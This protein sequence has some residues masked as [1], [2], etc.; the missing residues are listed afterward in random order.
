MGW[1]FEFANNN[2][3]AL[4]FHRSRY[5]SSR[6]T[7]TGGKGRSRLLDCD[8]T[9]S[10]F[11]RQLLCFTRSTP[12]GRSMFSQATRTASPVRNPKYAMNAKQR[13]HGS[14]AASMI[15]CD[16]SG[17]KKPLRLLQFLNRQEQLLPVELW[18]Q[19][20]PVPCRAQHAG[21]RAECVQDGLTT[22]A[23]AAADRSPATAGLRL[24]PDPAGSGL[25]P[26]LCRSGTG[27]A[28]IRRTTA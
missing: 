15:R 18:C 10:S 23:P 1:P 20:V 16:S 2:P 14:G 13:F 28:Q 7:S 21:E 8:F 22:Q 4:G 5:P 25:A 26:V 27:S 12:A 24:L 17:V 3:N 19:I 9:V 11:P 6:A